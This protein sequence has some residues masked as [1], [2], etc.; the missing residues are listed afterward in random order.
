MKDMETAQTEI[1]L[2]QWLNRNAANGEDWRASP[3]PC[4]LMRLHR[5][6]ICPTRSV[7]RKLSAIS[8]KQRSTTVNMRT[9]TWNSNWNRIVWRETS[10]L[11]S[12]TCYVK[13]KHSKPLHISILFILYIFIYSIFWYFKFVSE[14]LS[15]ILD[16]SL[17]HLLAYLSSNQEYQVMVC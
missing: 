16:R 17:G 14:T 2:L 7:M 8:R 11:S 4:L 3:L 12:E 1:I 13:I 10:N 15:S 5:G 9:M 6:R